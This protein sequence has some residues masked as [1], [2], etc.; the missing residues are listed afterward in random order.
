MRLKVPKRSSSRMMKK[1]EKKNTVIRDDGRTKNEV[2]S[3][4][5]IIKDKRAKEERRQRTNPKTRKAWADQKK[6]EHRE[7]VQ[8]KI[9]KKAAYQRSFQ[10]AKDSTGKRKGK[11]K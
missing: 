2:K 9:E 7:K 5:A 3:A 6:N 4:E 10:I 8:R 11:K 1:R